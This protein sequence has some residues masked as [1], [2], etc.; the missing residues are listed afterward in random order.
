MS[1]GAETVECRGRSER[2]GSSG[3]RYPAHRGILGWVVDHAQIVTADDMSNIHSLAKLEA[4]DTTK[5]EACA[6]LSVGHRVLGVLALDSIEQRPPE[7][8]RL[9]YILANFSAVALNNSQLFERVER[10][11][12]HDGLT[13]LLNHAAFQSRLNQMFDEARISGHDLS[14]VIADLDHF[15]QVNDRYLHQGG[16]HVL[17][18]VADLW[19]RL[20]PAPAVAARYGGEEFVFVLPNTDLR[21]AANHAEVLRNALEFAAIEFEGTPLRVTASF[22]VATLS[23]QSDSAAALVRQADTALYAAKRAGRNCVRIAPIHMANES[24]VPSDG[25]VAAIEREPSAGAYCGA[26]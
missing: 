10:M 26:V 7:F 1:V 12:R 24:E 19:R 23:L 11:A 3:N 2:P 6:P 16:D 14:L 21:E 17:K 22:G 18:S 4:D 9:L 15:K 13:G 25:S 8:E 20:I 5:W